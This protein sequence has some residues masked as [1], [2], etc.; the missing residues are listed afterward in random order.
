[1]PLWIARHPRVVLP[2]ATCYG[3]SEVPT[4]P[5]HVQQCAQ[6]LAQW[7]PPG[8]RITTSERERTRA[9]AQALA[10]LRPDL[11]AARSDARLNEMDF[12]HW[13]MTPWRCIPQSA[14]DAW[15]ADYPTHRFGGRESA[16]DVLDRVA[17]LVAD[18][19]AERR[20]EHRARR[21]AQSAP[22]PQLW[23]T[24]AGVCKALAFLQ[25]HPGGRLHS[26]A[27]WPRHSIDYGQCLPAS[28]WG[29]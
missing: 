8:C 4:D 25:S 27:Q 14:V 16:Q 1:M 18:Y 10:E 23:I 28:E 29:L 15:V 2:E 5:A 24:H 12:G 11:P 13:E 3:A 26:A 19:L 7:L 9:L 17:A 20:A 6:A 22:A 21:E